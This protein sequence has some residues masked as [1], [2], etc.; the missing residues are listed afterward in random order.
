MPPDA[1][2]R[3]RIIK[4]ALLKFKGKPKL[5]IAKWLHKKYPMEFSTVEN[6]RSAIRARTGAK[7]DQIK[8]MPTIRGKAKDSTPLKIPKGIKQNKPTVHVKADGKYLVTG[9]WHVPYHDE[10]S[11]EAMFKFAEKEGCDHLY[12]NGDLI[13]FY[14]VSQ[15]VKDPRARNVDVELELLWEILDQVAD[16]FDEKYYKSGNH[17]D[18]FTRR[19]W[20][21]TPELAVLKNFHVD[22]VLD[23]KSRGFK[24]VDS[25]QFAKFNSLWLVHGH[26]LAKGAFSPVN[27]ARGVFL[28]TRQTAATNHWHRTSSHIETGGLSKKVMT[29]YSIGCMCNLSPAYAPTNNWNHGFATIELDG[30]DYHFENY[31]VERGKVFST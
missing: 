30:N 11:I 14:K 25:T 5:T 7:T 8:S 6:A 16:R 4:E 26:E 12:L 19:I 10:S 15:W 29:C 2:Y 9:D 13:D 22:Q 31:T 18:R 20:Q 3:N 17:E 24:V 1:T 21:A 23:V 27:V 28:R